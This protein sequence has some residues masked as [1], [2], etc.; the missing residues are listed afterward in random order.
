MTGEELA[1]ASE[2]IFAAGAK[3][4]AF[5]HAIMKKGRPG[6]L[7]CVLCMEEDKTKV[8]S[9]IFANTSTL[10]VREKTCPRYMLSRKIEE[11]SLSDGSTVRRKIASGHG[12]SRAKWEADDLA[13]YARRR[14]VSL[15]EAESEVERA[16][17]ASGAEA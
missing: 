1:F 6:F 9:A 5:V 13:A 15:S 12:V 10:G 4:V 7:A 14:G 2:R 17:A 8:V 11:V 16:L 3:D